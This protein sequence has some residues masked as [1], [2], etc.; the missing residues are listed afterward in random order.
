MYIVYDTSDYVCIAVPLW[1][2]DSIRTTE[3]IHPA[4]AFFWPNLFTK[5]LFCLKP[6]KLGRTFEF[7]SKFG[8]D[9]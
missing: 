2:I 3:P 6:D 1:S 4:T 8:M 9:E 7:S 5:T